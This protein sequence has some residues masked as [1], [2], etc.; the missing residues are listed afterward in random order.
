MLIPPYRTKLPIPLKMQLASLIHHSIVHSI[1]TLWEKL[2]L[3]SEECL[4]CAVPYVHVK[5]DIKPL[6][7][8]YF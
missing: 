2:E 3:P 5:G 7:D 6:L 4:L 1:D 8:Q